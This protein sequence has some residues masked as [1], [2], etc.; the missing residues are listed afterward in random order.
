[1]LSLKLEC[2]S[3]RLELN[4]RLHSLQ[5]Q[6]SIN[7]THLE[8]LRILAC[9]DHRLV[10]HLLEVKFLDLLTLI[11]GLSRHLCL[12]GLTLIFIEINHTCPQI[13]LTHKIS[14]S[15]CMEQVIHK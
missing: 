2:H 1:M 9:Q 4:M 3:R 13:C 7:N 10:I 5:C 11:K 14:S 8:F 15:K 6:I 12:Q